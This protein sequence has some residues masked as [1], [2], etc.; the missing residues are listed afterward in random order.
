MRM[1]RLLAAGK[2]LVGA[3][4][5]GTRYRMTDPRA[6]PKFGSPQNPFRSKTKLEPAQSE[7]AAGPSTSCMGSVLPLGTPNVQA[8][9]TVPQ[10]EPKRASSQPA[11]AP[12]HRQSDPL[13]AGWLRRLAGMLSSMLW[14]RRTAA[15][16]YPAP[17]LTKPL[18]QGD[19]S[20]DNIRVVRNDLSDADLEIVR[21]EAPEARPAAEPVFQ[22]I[23]ESQ[24][25]DLEC[26]RVGAQTLG[27]CKS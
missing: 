8:D 22:A 16:N 3:E 17:R 26:G 19:L 13:P 14:W 23:A 27:G 1:V 21:A 12:T 24:P 9:P 5:P 25:A 6:L 4:D 7:A 20:L 11:C 2:S 18:V 10:D 15:G